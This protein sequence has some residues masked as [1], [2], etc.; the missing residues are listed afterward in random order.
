[1]SPEVL[2]VLKLDDYINVNFTDETSNGYINF[3]T[4]Y[5]ASQRKGASAH[6]PRSCIPGGGWEIEDLRT[7]VVPG[8]GPGNAGL[9]VNRVII[10]KGESRQ[11]VYYWFQQRG[12]IITNEYLVKWYLLVDALTRHRTDGAMVRLVTPVP[13]GADM[14]K[15]EAMLAGFMSQ[16]VP[17]LGAYIPE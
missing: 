1:M 17:G 6:S 16:V 15:A 7:V 11:L 3:Y 4:A 5:Y 10:A 8:V 12:R 14:A 13:Q 2:G 9:T